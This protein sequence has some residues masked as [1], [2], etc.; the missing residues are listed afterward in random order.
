MAIVARLDTVEKMENRVAYDLGLPA[1]LV[2]LAGPENYF[3]TVVTVLRDKNA[4]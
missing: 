3:L 2:A 4:Y 1:E